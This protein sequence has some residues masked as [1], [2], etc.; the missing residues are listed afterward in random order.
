MIEMYI[1]IILLIFCCYF[2][3]KT[4]SIPSILLIVGVM[5]TLTDILLHGV[6]GNLRVIIFDRIVGATPGFML[7]VLY[8][9]TNKK[10]GLGDGILLITLGLLLGFEHILV[11]FCIGLFLQ[12]LLAC[13]MLVT[14]KADK[15]TQIPFV[16]FLMLGNIS[17][18]LYVVA[19]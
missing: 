14:K 2:D 3:T 15:Q 18:L 4:K 6:L 11:I 16:P 9:I 10:V 17:M 8:F 5:V 13:F 12:S 19:F 7:L 1:S